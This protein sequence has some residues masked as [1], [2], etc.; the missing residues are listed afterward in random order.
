LFLIFDICSRDLVAR[1]HHVSIAHLKQCFVN[2]FIKSIMAVYRI[3]VIVG[4]KRVVYSV[5]ACIFVYNLYM[6]SLLCI[7]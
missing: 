2:T 5:A 1:G 3:E 4:A 6:K 7:A